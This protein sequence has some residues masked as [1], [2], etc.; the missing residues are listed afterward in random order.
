MFT[1][2]YNENLRQNFVDHLTFLYFGASYDHHK[3][4][5]AIFLLLT[6]LVTVSFAQTDSEI[7]KRYGVPTES[8]A[9]TEHIWM[10]PKYDAV[11]KY[12]R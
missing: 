1:C 8:F 12:V 4:I 3:N 9:I 11:V 2:I 6:V 10:T 7:R 5:S